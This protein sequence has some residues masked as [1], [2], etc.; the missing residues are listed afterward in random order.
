MRPLTQHDMDVAHAA[1]DFYFPGAQTVFD[2]LFDVNYM[3]W[4]IATPDISY[5]EFINN[6]LVEIYEESLNQP[7]SEAAA[8]FIVTEMEDMGLSPN[9]ADI[10]ENLDVEETFA[11]V[12]P[13]PGSRHPETGETQEEINARWAEEEEAALADGDADL[14]EGDFRE[15]QTPYGVMRLPIP[16]ID[17]LENEFPPVEA[18]PGKPEFELPP[19]EEE[20]EEEEGGGGG[21]GIGRRIFAADRLG[22]AARDTHW[23]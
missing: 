20:G 6:K 21:P 3:G 15:I 2:G 14:N 12:W 10:K 19:P 9:K 4:S 7:D 1:G 23:R 18:D 5:L 17:E 22:S 11:P 13:E 8:D 16:G